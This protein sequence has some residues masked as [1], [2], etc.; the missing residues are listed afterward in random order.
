MCAHG[1]HLDQGQPLLA[2]DAVRRTDV[3]RG[4]CISIYMYT[5]VCMCIYIYIHIS[6]CIY[7]YIYTYTYVYI[8]IYVCMHAYIYIYI[9]AIELD[10]T[11]HVWMR[12]VTRCDSTMLQSV[13]MSRR[14]TLRT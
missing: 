12:C 3:E 5:C 13:V 9:Y 6:M 1:R 4:L 2:R 11:R 8:Y 7:I 10:A 14:C